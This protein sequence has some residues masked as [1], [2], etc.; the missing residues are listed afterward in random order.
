MNYFHS[1][2][3]IPC[4]GE[5]ATRGS[6]GSIVLPAYFGKFQAS[7]SPC[8]KKKGRWHLTTDTRDYH[9]IITQIG[10]Y[11]RRL[12]HMNGS[13]N[14]LTQIKTGNSKEASKIVWT[15]MSE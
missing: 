3:K 7:K 1:K 5:T 11:V 8:L 4:S 9:L 13:G 10:K 15:V 2:H 6:Q 14:T 12:I